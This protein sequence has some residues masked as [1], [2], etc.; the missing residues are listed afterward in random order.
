[1]MATAIRI[2]LAD[3]LKIL[4]IHHQ[5]LGDLHAWIRSNALWV[6]LP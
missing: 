1:M 4:S 6:N 2:R 3:L 5:A